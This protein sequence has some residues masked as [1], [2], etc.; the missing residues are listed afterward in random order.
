[1][2]LKDSVFKIWEESSLTLEDVWENF[3]FKS[4]GIVKAWHDN[5]ELTYDG[6]KKKEIVSITFIDFMAYEYLNGTE[7]WTYISEPYVFG[8]YNSGIEQYVNTLT[9]Q[10]MKWMMINSDNTA[11]ILKLCRWLTKNIFSIAGVL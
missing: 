10:G 8:G 9:Q 11:K 6:L 5:A 3:K 4:K 2:R 1:M 7:D